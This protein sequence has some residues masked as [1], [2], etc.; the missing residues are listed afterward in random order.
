MEDMGY[1]EDGTYGHGPD[2]RVFSMGMGRQFG[3]DSREVGGSQSR[4]RSVH[5]IGFR[6][7]VCYRSRERCTRGNRIVELQIKISTTEKS[8]NDRRHN[9]GFLSVSI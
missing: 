2:V 4:Y 8:I 9:V 6:Q 3:G 7:P 5:D 1:M